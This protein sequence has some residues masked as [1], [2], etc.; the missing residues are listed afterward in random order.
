MDNKK[1]NMIPFFNGPFN[2]KYKDLNLWSKEYDLQI[3]NFYDI[4]I[5]RNIDRIKQKISNTILV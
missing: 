2:P 3:K 4:T 5:E 1:F